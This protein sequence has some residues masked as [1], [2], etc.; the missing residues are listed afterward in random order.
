MAMHIDLLITL[1]ILASAIILFLSERLSVD[2]V[3]LLV[4]IALGLS[5]VLTPQEVFSGLSEPA[6]ITILVVFVLAHGLEVSGIAERIGNFLVRAA[7]GSESRLI[8]AVMAAGA[9]LS[10]FMNNIAAATTLLPAASSAARKARVNP[11]RL[12]MPLGFS[13]LLGGMAT[14]F[15]TTNIVA[16]TVLKEN[17]YP[18][19]GILDFAPI[20]MLLVMIGIGYMLLVGRRMLPAKTSD[21]RAEVFRHAEDLLHTYQI[22]ERLF[23]ARVPA[24]SFLIE[25]SLAESNLRKEYG[26]NV[27]AIERNGSRILAPQPDFILQRGDVMVV[28][29]RLEAL[30]Q[31]EVEK[32]LNILPVQTYKECDLESDAHL[33]F[34]AVLSPRSTLIGQTLGEAHFRE[35]YGV[36]VLAVWN[37]ERVFRTGLA[38]LRLTF[39]DALL[40]Q[41]GRERL[42]VLRR[43]ADLIVLSEQ[44]DLN[45][46]KSNKGWLAVL[47]FGVSVLVAALGQFSV[48]EV[49]LAGALTM[50]I[51][52]VVSMEKV[53]R[54]IEWR[55][56]FLVAGMLPLGIAMTKTGAT[57]LFADALTR[58]FTPFGVLGLLFGLMTLTVL[59]SQAMKGAAV[60]AVIAPIAISAARNFGVDPRAMVMGVALATSMAFVTPLGHPVN[61]LMM[62]PGG[63]RFRDYFK[64]GLPLT[65]LLFGVVMLLLPVFWDL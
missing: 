11:S 46:E 27:L 39:G 30:R 53:Y 37:G 51:T 12:L 47:I 28:E 20:G 21:E 57:K 56:I 43:E 41:G 59:L 32:S 33:I 1:I 17:G 52:N 45:P 15:T 9:L 25:K 24:N 35:K 63:Y 60:S 18:G 16:S 34:E 10:L 31:S 4:L 8:L 62:G 2:L 38:N 29:G 42:P 19:F 13:T 5:H 26:L 65:A 22:G 61:I 14:L 55:I 6:V 50:V 36:T 64:V 7:D 40:L 44:D 3:A 49:M 58:L 23:R 48:S 54:V